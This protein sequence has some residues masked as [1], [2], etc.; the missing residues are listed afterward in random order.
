MKFSSFQPGGSLSAGGN[1]SEPLAEHVGSRQV[2]ILQNWSAAKCPLSHNVF[3]VFFDGLHGPPASAVPHAGVRLGSGRRVSS[4]VYADAVVLLSWMSNLF[5]IACPA[6]ARRSASP[7]APPI[8]SLW[9]AMAQLVAHGMLDNMCCPSLPLK[10]MGLVFH[11]SGSMS[12][13]FAKA[14]NGK[15]AAAQLSA[16]HRAPMCSKS[17]R[18]KACRNEDQFVNENGY[19]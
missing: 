13:A 18:H 4:L 16:K 19:L 14:Q 12:P 17:P 11:G 6:F 10:Y 15:D 2:T 5:W 7:S 8:Q 1:C 9:S 3:G